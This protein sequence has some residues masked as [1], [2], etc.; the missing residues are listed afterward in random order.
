MY[1]DHNGP[2]SQH[3]IL[4]RNHTHILFYDDVNKITFL[5]YSIFI[6]NDGSNGREGTREAVR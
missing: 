2:V 1:Y 4:D 5:F 6:K 3:K